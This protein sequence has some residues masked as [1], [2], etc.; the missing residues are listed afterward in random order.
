MTNNEQEMT[1]DEGWYR[2]ALSF[3]YKLKFD[4]IPYFVIRHSLFKYLV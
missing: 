4:R 1:I 2:F 3:L